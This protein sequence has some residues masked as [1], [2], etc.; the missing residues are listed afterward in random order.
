[1]RFLHPGFAAR[2]ISIVDNNPSPT[3]SEIVSGLRAN[4]CRCTGYTKI[5]DAIERYAQMRRGEETPAKRQRCRH[6]NITTEIHGP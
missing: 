2:G 4:L 3:R 1:M 6:R 5:V